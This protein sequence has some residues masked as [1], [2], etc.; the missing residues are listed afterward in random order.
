MAVFLSISDV[1]ARWSCGRTFVYGAIAEME[2][3]GYL[4]RIWLGRV[5]RIA[6][7]SLERWEQAHSTSSREA[8]SDSAASLRAANDRPTKQTHRPVV[9][10][11][12]GLLTEWRA[13]RAT[14]HSRPTRR[15]TVSK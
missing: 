15:A 5:Q 13:L 1:A 3:E 7:E 11:K 14:S 2:R 10:T 9:S 12:P 4:R 6:L 8:D